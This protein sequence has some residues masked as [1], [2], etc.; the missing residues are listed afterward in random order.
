MIDKQL[1]LEKA[2]CLLF[3]KMEINEDVKR[4]AKLI[5]DMYEKVSKKIMYGNYSSEV[6]KQN[7]K[8]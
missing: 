6:L 3:C 1:V 8:Q 4:L 7:K 5:D 2:G